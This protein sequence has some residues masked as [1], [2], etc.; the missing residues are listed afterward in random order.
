MLARKN[1]IGRSLFSALLHRKWFFADL[2]V[3]R[4][5]KKR[6]TISARNEEN[7]YRSSEIF[8]RSLNYISSLK[9]YFPPS[10]FDYRT[11]WF[12]IIIVTIFKASFGL[13][14]SI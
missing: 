5:L 8:A 1:A 14:R 13:F 7:V 2:L 11:E 6:R 4:G 12:S 10:S 3:E 9:K